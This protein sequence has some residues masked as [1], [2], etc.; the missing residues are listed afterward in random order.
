VYL[1]GGAFTFVP[2][3]NNQDYYTTP[4]ATVNE[5]FT[6][7]CE[8]VPLFDFTTATA[9]DPAAGGDHGVGS[10]AAGAGNPM[11][12]PTALQ[13]LGC[14]RITTVDVRVDSRA[15]IKA[16]YMEWYPAEQYDMV[17]TNP[18]FTLALDYI[19]TALDDCKVGGFVVMLV[20][21]NFLGSVGRRDFWLHHMPTYCIVH[22]QRPR[23]TS[24]GGDSCEYCHM[25]WK[26][27]DNPAFTKTFVV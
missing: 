4:A 15:E 7:F 10:A 5:F 2:M 9:L 23:F 25:V 26:K 11:P 19:V 18:P 6:K 12:Y 22:A 16:N 21:L 24:G 8:L 14:T 17:I 20:R 3:R 1:I 13:R 27:G